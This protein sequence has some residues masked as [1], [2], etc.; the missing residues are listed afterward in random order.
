MFTKFAGGAAAAV[1]A[2]AVLFA[3]A[4]AAQAQSAAPSCVS[5]PHGGNGEGSGTMRGDFNL[6]TAPYAHCGNVRLLTKST[7]VYYQCLYRNA[8]G[9][10]WWWVRVAGTSTYGWMAN[11]NL[12]FIS[13]DENGNGVNDAVNCR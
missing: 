1:L 10:Y 13:T 8:Y 3:P 9:N 4:S 2:S 6:K 12:R 5:P 7:L 11:D